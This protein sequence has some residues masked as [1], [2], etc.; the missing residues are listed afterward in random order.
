M[1]ST[2][3]NW[4]LFIA[5]EL[6]DNALNEIGGLIAQ[7]DPSI[8]D[9]VRWT[10]RNNTHITL[11]FIGDT[12]PER[13]IE[14]RNGLIEVSNTSAPLK[15]TLANTGVFPSPY[16]PKILWV[17]LSGET[18]RLTQLQARV[19]GAMSRIKI[20]KED[21]KFT[22]HITT[23]RVHRNISTKSAGDIGFGWQRIN[24]PEIRTQINVNEISLFRSHLDD[25]SPRYEKL[26]STL[27]TH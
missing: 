15:L 19:E 27:L 6:P 1:N 10:P 17:G 4:R 18:R 7:V 9:N 22:P 24:K 21:R 12:D 23:G 5:I 26:F 14:I 2:D 8:A 16:A 13:F 20:T 25:D 11:K 3:Q